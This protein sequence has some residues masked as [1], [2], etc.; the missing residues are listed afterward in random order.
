MRAAPA[1]AD[2]ADVWR[3]SD[4]VTAEEAARRTI[5]YETFVERPP[6]LARAEQAR[7]RYTALYRAYVEAA[8]ELG[9]PFREPE[10]PLDAADQR[11]TGSAGGSGGPLR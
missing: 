11:G 9:V 8:Q 3:W 2:A 7:E 10:V 5:G 4:A 1:G 6:D